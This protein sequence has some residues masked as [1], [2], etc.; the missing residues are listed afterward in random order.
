MCKLIRF[1]YT[2]I[3]FHGFRDYLIQNHLEDCPQC[4]RKWAIARDIEDFFAM[5]EWIKK[6]S[7]LWPRIQEKIKRKRVEQEQAPSGK[8]EI[9]FFPRWRW[10]LAGLALFI[11]VG[12]IFLIDKTMIQPPIET[13]ISFALKNPQIKIIHAEIQGKKAKPFI[14][15][16]TDKLY[17]WFDEIDQEEH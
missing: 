15:Q 7:S 4:Q 13:R 16:T 6:E 2:T 17:I 14:Y 10:A 1:L 5:P 12:M 9:F 11:L 3:P 8:K